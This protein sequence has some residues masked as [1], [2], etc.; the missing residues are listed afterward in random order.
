MYRMRWYRVVCLLLPVVLLVLPPWM[1]GQTQPSS[2]SK[3]P[4]SQNSAEHLT[5]WNRLSAQFGETL[6]THEETLTELS[7][8]LKTSQNSG[9]RLTSLLEQLSRQNEGL[10]NYNTQIGERMMERDLDLTEAYAKINQ[11]EGRARTLISAVVILSALL[12]II[13]LLKAAR[14][15]LKLML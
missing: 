14:L 4:L 15:F 5:A 2:P 3:P 7:E 11:L 8:K 12:L 10:R 6:K 9:A 13:I 1:Y